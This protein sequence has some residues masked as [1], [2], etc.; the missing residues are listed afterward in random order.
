MLTGHAEESAKELPEVATEALTPM[1]RHYLEVKAAHP[2]ALVFY[3]MGDFFE[4]FYDDAV[5]AAPVLEVTLTARH[6]GRENEAPMCGVPHHALDAYLGRAVR[7]GFKVAICDQVEDPA[8]AKGLVR[9]EVVRVVTPGTLSEPGLLEAAEDNLL[10]VVVWEGQ[11]GA[12]ALL[13][14]ST[15]LFEVQRV[16]QASDAVDAL[17]LARPREVVFG[18]VLPTDLS[19]WLEA[20]VSCRTEVG[21]DQIPRPDRAGDELKRQLRIETLRGL[22]IDEPDVAVQAAAVALRYVRATQR[23]ELGHLRHLSLR[24]GSDALVLDATTLANLD[25][26]QGSRD[27]SRQH[28]LLAT[29]DAT[30]TAAGGRLLRQWLRRPLRDLATIGARHE[31]VVELVADTTRRRALGDTLRQIADLER[32]S[33]RA[34]LGSIGPR[35]AAALRDTLVGA[36]EVLALAG[37]GEAVRTKELAHTPACPGLAAELVRMLAPEPSHTVGDGGVIAAGV[38]AEL[39]RAR[40]LARDVRRVILEREASERERT[41]ISSLKIR[42]N[43]VFGYYIEITKANARNVPAE[44]IRKQTLVNAERYITPEIKALEEEVLAAEE[45]QAA[46]EV[47]W[48]NRVVEAI[49]AESENLR[50]LAHAL[51]EIDVLR[52]FADVAA[53]RS[54]VAPRMTPA[55]GAMVVR[56]GRHPIVEGTTRE[57][58]VPNDALLDPDEAQIVVLTGPNM[59]GKSTWLR[60]I[61]L[62]CLLAQAGSLV[63]AASAELSVVDRIFTRVGA[64]DDLARGES[65]FMVEMIETARILNQASRNSLVILDEVGRGT[66]TFD[67]LALA[68]AIVE[69]LHEK[70]GAK[71][72]FATHYHQLTELASTLPRVVNRTMAVREWQDRIV[73]LK[74]VV[75]GS[76]DKSYG[77]Q[78][79]RLAGLPE[80]VIQRANEVLG[81]LEAQELDMTGKPRLAR[82]AHAPQ[83]DDGNE[84]LRLFAAPEEIVAK[85]LRDVDV[86]RLTPLAALNLVATLRER[87]GGG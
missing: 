49:A 46:L 31:V 12:L 33:T 40:A 8:E 52:G 81:N 51:A 13:D 79:A 20:R 54:W 75:D 65:T 82:G 72:V 30:R 67:G 21:A 60:Q 42:Y 71:T 59:G 74:R 3:R 38:D 19:L 83:V 56:D 41:G 22:G 57:P 11:V 15:G 69:H 25:V 50:R 63:P 80:V 76:S 58:F 53:K 28:S 77:L 64:S 16:R 47:E 18:G 78:V 73:F 5:T 45:R 2:D 87:L 48:W 24:E 61:A 44:Y 10:A 1:L 37:A 39:D 62:I 66:S 43:K 27:T 4:L 84:Q 70:V 86:D 36:P 85:T 23:Q 32:S 29:V 26:L 34:V 68:W 14:V 6:K 17:E 7:A 9:R 55:G 35:E